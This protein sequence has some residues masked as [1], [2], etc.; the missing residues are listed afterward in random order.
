MWQMAS[1]NNEFEFEP[2]SIPTSPGR[3][4]RRRQLLHGDMAA[5]GAEQY[6]G[7]RL[8]GGSSSVNGEQAVWPTRRLLEATEAAVGG[9]PAWAPDAVFALLRQL[10]TYDGVSPQ[11]R[12]TSGPLDIKQAPQPAG[13]DGLANDFVNATASVFEAVAPL[14]VDYNDP[15]TPLSIFPQW[16]LTQQPSGARASASTAMLSATVR[17][18]PNLVI[19]TRATAMRVLFD[20][21][22]LPGARPRAVGVEYTQAGTGG[23][24]AHA[25]REVII[26]A[27]HR[28]SLLLESSG[29]GDPAIIGPLLAA[30]GRSVVAPLPGVGRNLGNDGIVLVNLNATNAP[31]LASSTV[32]A[33]TLYGGGAF[34]PWPGSVGLGSSD[35]FSQFIGAPGIA[36]PE[37]FTIGAL[38][39]NVSSRGT[40]HIQSAD[41]LYEPLVDLNTF[42]DVTDQA[43]WLYLMR[44]QVAPIVAAMEA[45][46]YELLSPER[47][48]IFGTDVDVTLD[49]VFGA[50]IPSH[51]WFGTCAA[52]VSVEGGAVV[53]SAG[54]VFGVDGLRVADASIFP[55][56][57]DGNTGIPAYVAGGIVGRK[58]VEA[59]G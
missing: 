52:G 57:L 6:M 37:T 22:G 28:S 7:G 53:D 15:A 5:L 50:Y 8:L 18:R 13:A 35:R 24:V 54:R 19:A 38:L 42:N 29:I 20:G 4:R 48:V 45:V 59:W 17:A 32:P 14:V 25:T 41:P 27:G 36:G 16:Q 51:H 39:L 49:W 12:G 40:S 31:G 55:L 34:L 56:K 30:V 26:A 33:T 44:E 23:L 10:E 2:E 3:R 47:D 58:V 11:P 46:G 9:D 21:E 43:N 1:E